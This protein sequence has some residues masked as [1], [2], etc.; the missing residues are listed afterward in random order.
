MIVF[1]ISLP[2]WAFLAHKIVENFQEIRYENR[3]IK[4]KLTSVIF[5]SMILIYL[6]RYI[7]S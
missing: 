5:I 3:T 7:F 6:L 1:L 2:I 4:K